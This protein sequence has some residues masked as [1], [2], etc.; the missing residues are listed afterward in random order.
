MLWTLQTLQTFRLAAADGDAGRVRDVAA[1]VVTWTARAVILGAGRW[2]MPRRVLVPTAVIG[3]PQPDT[4]RL[5]TAL[6]RAQ[7][8]QQPDRVGDDANWALRDA[9][10]LIGCDVETAQEWLGVVDDAL[11]DDRDWTLRAL[12]VVCPETH[13]TQRQAVPTAL[14]TAVAWDR[15]TVTLDAAEPL[16]V[17]P[18]MEYGG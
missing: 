8:T 2:P 9:G 11:I 1:D 5:P 15:R 13:A 17:R 4:R 14:V 6:T 10:E 18:R 12:V 7:I 16:P 3:Q